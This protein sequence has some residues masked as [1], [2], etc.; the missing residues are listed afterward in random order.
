MNHSESLSA[1][2]SVTGGDTK[3]IARRLQINWT[4]QRLKLA[5]AGCLVGST[6]FCFAAANDPSGYI[7]KSGWHE[8]QR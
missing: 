8:S 6:C 2:S 4:A 1:A 7:R 3:R 5:L